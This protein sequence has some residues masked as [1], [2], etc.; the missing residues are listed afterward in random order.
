MKRIVF[1]LVISIL[2]IS[3]CQKDLGSGSNISPSTNS[4][5]SGGS[6]SG[7]GSGSSSSNRAT[8]YLS[9]RSDNPYKFYFD[10]VYQATIP[11]DTYRVYTVSPGYHA[12]R[13]VQYSGYIFYPT[14]ETYTFTAVAGGVY[15]C[16]FPED[17][18]GK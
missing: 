4:N 12:I 15:T 1:L 5:S 18:F 2:A 16:V 7:G 9:N 13:V 8:L 17:S 3:G 6:S 14:D 11:G 10:D